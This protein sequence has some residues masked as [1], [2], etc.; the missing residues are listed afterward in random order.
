[1]VASY[2]TL[3]NGCKEWHD[4]FTCP[5]DDCIDGRKYS[6]MVK[7]ARKNR[8]TL[9]ELFNKGYEAKEAASITGLSLRTVYRAKR[10]ING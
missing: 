2:M 3:D 4:C 5:F 1:M 6:D 8:D 7:T 9:R 10:G